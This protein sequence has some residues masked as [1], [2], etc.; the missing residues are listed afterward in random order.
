MKKILSIISFLVVALF[1]A[2][3]LTNTENYMYSRT[4][5][6]PV[7]SEQPNAAQIQGVQYLDGLGRTMQSIAIKATPNGKD[8]VVSSLYD[9]SG[10]K[11][12]EYLPQPVD[13]QN[14]AYIPGIGENSVNAYYGV[15]NAYSE[16]LYEKSPLGRIEKSAAPGAD[17]QMSST[18]TQKIEYLS[19]ND[20]EVKRF[21]A[22]T[23][24]NSSTQINDTSIV[25]A[26]DDS[27]TTNGFYNINTLYK[28]VIRDEDNNETHTFINSKKQSVLVRK[29]N[30]KPNGI[31]ENLDTYYVYNDFDNIAYVIPPKASVAVLTPAV[32]NS[33]CYQYKYDKYN[34][35]AEKKIP[36]KGWEFL[37][38]DKQ[39]RI[40]LAQDT[41]LR[42]ATNSF[43]KRGWMFSKYDKFGRTVYT[44]FFANTAERPAM[45]AALNNMSANALNN[46]TQSTAPFTLSGIDVYYTKT[47]FP[48]GSMTILSVNYYDE[49]PAG[50]PSQPSQIQ[51]Q[52]TLASAPTVIVSNGM[53]SVRSI[54]TLPTASY[55]KNIENDIYL[56]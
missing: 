29:I 19:N 43:A 21:K 31:V 27:Y 42:T 25:I 26:S 48:T 17:W 36:G 47:A 44:G 51:S 15:P 14:G 7:T 16:V 53:S 45:Q 22:V 4:Y 3:S 10:K 1:H 11:T 6:E 32:L 39:N 55:T 24:W 20:G 18:H 28:M 46:E 34:R 30:K 52:A 56:V 37:V 9:Q 54:K 2:Q 33:L 50:S 23:T 49:Y 5:L 35:L 13:S 12:K 38:Y 8:L 41:S 40:V